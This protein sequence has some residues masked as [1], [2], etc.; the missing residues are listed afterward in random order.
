MKNITKFNDNLI[1]KNMDKKITHFKMNQ[2]YLNDKII[3]TLTKETITF[4]DFNL[5]MISRLSTLSI[6]MNNTK[7]AIYILNKTGDNV[8][9]NVY[10]ED[11]LSSYQENF[12]LI[13]LDFKIYTSN[14]NQVMN[15]I[16]KISEISKTKFKNLIII[17]LN[18]FLFLVIIIY[19]FLLLLIFVYLFILLK[20]LRS[21]KKEM[22]EKINDITVKEILK[23]KIDNL[24][25][26]L[27]FYD[28]DINKTILK[29]NRLYDDY[30][31]N[32]NLKLKEELKLLKREGKKEFGKENKNS[33]CIKDISTIKE[34][35]L[36]K[37][38][39][40]NKIFLYLIIN[41]IIIT[42]AI[43]F[44]N[45]FIWLY[46][47]RKE[48]K[49]MEW[50]SINDNA[51][52]T[53]NK[54]ISSYLLMIY[55]NQTLE[56]ISKEY[57]S[58]NFI[59]YIFTELTP[60][61][62][63]GKYNK[64]INNNNYLSAIE[65]SENCW[66]IYMALNIDIF[67]KLFDKFMKEKDQF[68]QTMTFLCEMSF[69]MTF[70]N[71]KAIF[72]QLFSLVQKGIEN[73]NN[74]KYSDIITSIKKKEI[75]EISLI[76]MSVHKYLIDYII[77][78]NKNI[79]LMTIKEIGNKLIITNIIVYPIIFFLIFISFFVYVK[80]V[81]NNCKKIIHIKKIFKICNLN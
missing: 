63:L 62:N 34:Y 71:Y 58:N 57:E 59:S 32:Y 80:N 8:F 5:L 50:K 72:L 17:F 67:N 41:I 6:D 12:Y 53:T 9:N 23:K 42:L 29:L 21:I 10:L 43:Y 1:L 35:K 45:L 75:L 68:Q 77:L 46:T 31:D 70:N 18:I 15:E 40:R 37:Y 60:L 14:L 74:I 20:T 16:G 27:K 73:F 61:Y 7:Q 25:M 13:I 55:D 24:Q 51:I 79:I 11:K 39:I 47:F 81:N 65:S 76:Y 78:I 38:A 44:I 22:K 30:R 36:Y 52:I 56:E 4:S 2:N 54:L 66:D 64:Y 48:S 69:I 3:L 33:N 26:L 28:N 19:F 49:I